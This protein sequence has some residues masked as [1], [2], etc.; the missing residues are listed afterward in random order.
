MKSRHYATLPRDWDRS[1]WG[2][3]F[4]HLRTDDAPMLL[5]EM[6]AECRMRAR[7]DGEP[8]RKLLFTT[9]AAARE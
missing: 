5:G 4:T 3:L 9:R 2:V 7:F 1:L 8:T 6:W